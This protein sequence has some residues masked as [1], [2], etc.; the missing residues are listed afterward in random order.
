MGTAAVPHTYTIDRHFASI[1][2]LTT[3]QLNTAHICYTIIMTIIIVLVHISIKTY[4][5]TSFTYRPRRR[6]PTLLFQHAL[7]NTLYISFF[8]A[9][10][11]SRLMTISS[12]SHCCLQLPSSWIRM[13][14]STCS[15]FLPCTT[16]CTALLNI[17]SFIMS[18]DS[19]SRLKINVSS[20]YACVVGL[21]LE[22]EYSC[23]SKN[24]F[25]GY[26]DCFM[27]VFFSES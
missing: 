5:Y 8:R 10:V 22:V 26:F 7:I 21:H 3:V 4:K 19:D 15:C 13:S 14:L 17:F 18:N 11:I 6:V 16:A 2:H 12:A 27:R 1:R 20:V 9:S 23:S 24:F 25:V